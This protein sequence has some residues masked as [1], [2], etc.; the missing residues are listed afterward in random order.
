MNKNSST[1]PV[2]IGALS[3]MFLEP[4]MTIYSWRWIPQNEAQTS[5][6]NQEGFQVYTDMAYVPS[7][8]WFHVGY[9][10][11]QFSRYCKIHHASAE[12]QGLVAEFGPKPTHRPV[13][14]A[15]GPPP[16]YQ[17]SDDIF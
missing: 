13:A 2:E 14:G 7:S 9:I 17:V 12:P 4:K 11:H 6:K 16:K 5:T 15:L 8:S 10:G 1:S 3:N